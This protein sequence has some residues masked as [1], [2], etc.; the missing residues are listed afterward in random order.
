MASYGGFRR[1]RISSAAAS[2][3]AAASENSFAIKEKAGA[4]SWAA[5]G[6]FKPRAP[7]ADWGGKTASTHN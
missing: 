6:G 5:L 2:N 4:R 1:R 3:T 7:S